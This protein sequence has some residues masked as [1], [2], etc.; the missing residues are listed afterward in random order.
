MEWTKY[1]EIKIET[2]IAEYIPSNLIC[3]YA[4]SFESIQL[5]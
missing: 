1:I 2:T 5:Y 3:L 4:R